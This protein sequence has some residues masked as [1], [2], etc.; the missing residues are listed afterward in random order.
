MIHTKNENFEL[1]YFKGY[2]VCKQGIQTWVRTKWVVL[3]NK[4]D[5]VWYMEGKLFNVHRTELKKL[6]NLNVEIN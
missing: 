4:G 6:Y 3:N 5:E 1:H 2:G